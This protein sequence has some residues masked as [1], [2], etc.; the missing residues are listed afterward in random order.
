MG[1]VTINDEFPMVHMRHVVRGREKNG[2]A[3]Y[4]AKDTFGKVCLPVEP[5]DHECLAFAIPVKHSETYD[6]VSFK[7]LIPCKVDF[8]E[9][10]DIVR[11]TDIGWDIE[12]VQTESASF[13]SKQSPREVFGIFKCEFFPEILVVVNLDSYNW[14]VPKQK[15]ITEIMSPLTQISSGRKYEVDAVST[16]CEKLHVKSEDTHI[17]GFNSPTLYGWPEKQYLRDEDYGMLS[18]H[19]VDI[20]ND[21][22]DDDIVRLKF[23]RSNLA[24]IIPVI[25][26]ENAVTIFQ[27]YTDDELDLF[28][29]ACEKV[30]KYVEYRLKVLKYERFKR[31]GYYSFVDI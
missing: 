25:K 10:A 16:L 18:T 9:F 27:N 26:S 22:I 12:Y 2:K 17:F 7:E 31:T 1:G 20:I 21:F 28:A 8:D 3:T 23:H 29:G 15:D 30:Y 4:I 24:L 6:I 14:W 11:D 5:I 19:E 13:I